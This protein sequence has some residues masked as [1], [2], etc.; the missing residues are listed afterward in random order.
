MST[1]QATELVATRTALIALGVL[2]A[3]ASTKAAAQVLAGR[4]YGHGIILPIENADFS[5]GAASAAYP[6]T[7]LLSTVGILAFGGF[8]TWAAM[9][10]RLPAWIPGLLVGGGIANLVDRLLFGAVHDWLDLGT[11]VVN[12]A[13]ISVFAGILG[14]FASLLMARNR[15]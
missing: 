11:V 7:L 10:K 12:L 13:D 2:L 6:V 9:R 1:E 15:H 3:D 8:A 4:G 5:L 14:Y